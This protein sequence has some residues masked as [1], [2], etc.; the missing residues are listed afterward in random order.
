MEPLF[1]SR[2][3]LALTNSTKAADVIE[4]HAL[5]DFR[6][7]GRR[8]RHVERYGWCTEIS[9]DADEFERWVA[10]GSAESHAESAPSRG[11]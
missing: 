6:S 1:N 8:L 9:V 7:V 2:H 3:V 10:A 11:A 5:A 4:R